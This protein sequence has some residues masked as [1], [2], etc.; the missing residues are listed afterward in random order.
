MLLVKRHCK[1][2]F[3]SG[4][5]SNVFKTAQQVASVIHY[6]QVNFGTVLFNV[7]TRSLRCLKKRKQS[8]ISW[9]TLV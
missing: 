6:V 4:S 8:N 9:I 3:R 1:A 5:R 7:V 2:L